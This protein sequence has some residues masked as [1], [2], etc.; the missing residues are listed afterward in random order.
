MHATQ[1][2]SA[3]LILQLSSPFTLFTCCSSHMRVR[4]CSTCCRSCTTARQGSP[5]PVEF[6]AAQSPHCRVLTLNSKEVLAWR[7]TPPTQAHVKIYTHTHIRT[8]MHRKMMVN[9]SRR[10]L[11]PLA[12]QKKGRTEGTTSRGVQVAW[13]GS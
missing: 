2:L 6:S 13:E 9:T 3:H 1:T 12:W 4:L 8:Y 7:V 11:L 5:L 10:G